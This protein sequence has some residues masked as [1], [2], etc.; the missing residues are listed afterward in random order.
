MTKKIFLIAVLTLFFINKNFGQTYFKIEENK[1]KNCCL[2]IPTQLQ[3]VESD[4]ANAIFKYLLDSVKFEYRYGYGACEDRAHF[5]SKSLDKKGIN[6]NKIW[7]FAPIRYTLI[8]KK[9]LSVKDPLTIS[10]KI[11][12]TYHVAPIIIVKNKSKTDTV[13]IDPSLESNSPILY[14][15]WLKMLNCPE[16]IFTF[17]ESNMYLFNS[18]DGFTAWRNNN[19]SDNENFTIPKWF[20]NIISGDFIPYDDNSQSIPKGMAINEIAVSIYNQEKGNLSKDELRTI[21]GN[22]NN[23]TAFLDDTEVNAVINEAFK[24]K[25]KEY[26]NRYKEKY[27]LRVAYWTNEY[28]KI[29]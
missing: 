8:S 6:N 21:L 19:F 7:C 4:K 10:D 20:P 1:L 5:I 24:I 22:I 3:P 13:V 9:E 12:W 16:A 11:I 26:I 27:K 29:K 15:Q 28:N 17:T 18:L 2:P 23:I 25:Y 14:S